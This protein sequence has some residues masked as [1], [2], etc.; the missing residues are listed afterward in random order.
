MNRRDKPIILI[1]FLFM[2]AWLVWLTWMVV[3]V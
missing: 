2:A 3:H 1:G